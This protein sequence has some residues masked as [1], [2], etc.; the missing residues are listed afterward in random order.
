LSLI[1]VYGDESCQNGHKYMVLGT[2]WD[3]ENC[4]NIIEEEVKSLRERTKFQ[5][6][7]H[8]TDLKN[9]QL[10]TYKELI[11]IFA[12][13]KKMNKLEFRALVVDQSDATHKIY[14]NDDELHFYK[15]FFWLIYKNMR[16]GNFYDILLDRKSNSV[17]GR[18]TDLKNS[19]NNR[20]FNDNWNGDITEIFQLL[21]PI[22]RVEPRDGSQI[23]LQLSDVFAG[24]IAYVWNGH[25]KERK[26]A[27]PDNPKVKLVEH[28]QN[29]LNLDLASP[30]KPW[31]SPSFNIW[32]FKRSKV[33]K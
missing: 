3:M 6:E 5:K 16:R 17:K 19:L 24:A 15:M 14:S 4:C 26:I 2:I 29:T 28:I 12:A 9:H 25:Y 31:E 21:N 13:H 20:W 27:N 30:H 11:N 22:R 32:Q 23:G 8:W 7:F 33:K 10:I 18:L 1:T